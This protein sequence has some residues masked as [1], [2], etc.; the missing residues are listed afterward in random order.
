MTRV[1]EMF[2]NFL[3]GVI[4]SFI[5]AH[6]HAGVPVPQGGV[7]TLARPAHQTVYV[8]DG[9]DLAWTSATTWHTWQWAGGAE[10]EYVDNS[11]IVVSPLLKSLLVCRI[12]VAAVGGRRCRCGCAS[13]RLFS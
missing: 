7:L 4:I 12:I 9:I 10:E 2:H 1:D 8:L 3:P 13:F 5:H 6:Y 11:F